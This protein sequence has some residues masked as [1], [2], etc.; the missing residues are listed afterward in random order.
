MDDYCRDKTKEEVKKILEEIADKALESFR[1][2]EYAEIM[3][4]NTYHSTIK[5]E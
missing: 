4:D 1:G 5:Q 2:A 3:D